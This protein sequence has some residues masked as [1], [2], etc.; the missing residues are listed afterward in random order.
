MKKGIVLVLFMSMI[1]GMGGLA[2]AQQQ[3]AI[4][5]EQDSV[6]VTNVKGTYVTGKVLT[7]EPDTT[8]YYRVK[9]LTHYVKVGFAFH[10]SETATQRML[11]C[12]QD[13]QPV[14]WVS[15]PRVS[16]RDLKEVA[17][18]FDE[19]G[20]FYCYEVNKAAKK[21][22]G[23]STFSAVAATGTRPKVIVPW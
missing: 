15:G 13:L 3:E 21:A 12:N 16:Y 18:M 6:G 9:R 10:P 14:P 2:C 7:T 20:P 19:D 1:M 22:D 8:I 17:R 23:K 11:L 5:L 4:G